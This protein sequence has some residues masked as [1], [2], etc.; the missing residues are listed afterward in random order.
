[1][2]CGPRAGTGE[3]NFLGTH[4]VCAIM[5]E[6]VWV[7]Y[8]GGDVKGLA[9]PKRVF[10]CASPAEVRLCTYLNDRRVCHG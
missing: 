9:L 2:Q 7:S 4:Y 3:P 6:S 1:M 5:T 8:A 10:P